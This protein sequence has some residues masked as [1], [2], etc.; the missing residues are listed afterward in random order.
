MVIEIG[1]PLGK[2][3][4]FPKTLFQDHWSFFRVIEDN[5]LKWFSSFPL[6]YGFFSPSLEI[7]ENWDLS[8]TNQTL[9]CHKIMML[10]SSQFSNI[11][12]LWLEIPILFV[13]VNKHAFFQWVL[14]DICMSNS[15]YKVSNFEFLFQVRRWQ[16]VVV[17][18][19]N[20][21]S[22]CQK[23]DSESNALKSISWKMISNKVVDRTGETSAGCHLIRNV[24]KDKKM[25]Y[26]FCVNIMEKANFM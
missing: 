8:V 14:L 1:L 7:N 11:I 21:R 24:E 5:S 4:N 9:S 23:V 19:R 2:W 18:S 25:F 26:S 6:Y 12:R 22:Y 16:V 10:I 13:S 17:V 3:E 15:K 20:S